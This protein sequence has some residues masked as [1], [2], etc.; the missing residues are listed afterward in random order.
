MRVS[1]SRIDGSIY[2]LLMHMLEF[3]IIK[4]ADGLTD[5]DEKLIKYLVEHNHPVIRTRNIA[6]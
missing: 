3:L 5:K 4:Y 2:Q 6:V 1:V